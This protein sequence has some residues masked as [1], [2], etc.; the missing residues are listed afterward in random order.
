MIDNSVIPAEA[1]DSA[2]R[3]QVI[4]DRLSSAAA[5]LKGVAVSQNG[6]LHK[7]LDSE[8]WFKKEYGDVR[9]NGS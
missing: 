3:K 6:T 5:R 7:L 2:I 9:E 8:D 1:S 4:T